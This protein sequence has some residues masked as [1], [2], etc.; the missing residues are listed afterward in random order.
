MFYPAHAARVGVYVIGAGVH[1]YVCMFVDK[2]IF[3]SYV[4]D[5]LTFSNN[6]GKTSRR[7]YID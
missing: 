4:S 1:I 6:H 2:N 5:R 3:E 7:I